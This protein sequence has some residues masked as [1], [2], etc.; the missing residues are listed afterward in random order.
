MRQ[1]GMFLLRCKRDVNRLY[2]NRNSD[3]NTVANP[4]FYY[5][6]SV[7]LITISGIPALVT[8]RV[9]RV[10]GVAFEALAM[11]PASTL[12]VVFAPFRIGFADFTMLGN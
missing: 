2:E 8:L 11:L 12:G 10:T 4:F 1:D 5:T 3:W 7:T 9:C 6:G